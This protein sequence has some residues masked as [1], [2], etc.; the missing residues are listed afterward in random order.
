MIILSILAR[1]RM[2]YDEY[3]WA[4]NKDGAPEFDPNK[5]KFDPFKKSFATCIAQACCSD[6][7]EWDRELGQ[8]TPHVSTLTTKCSYA[9][10]K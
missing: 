10:A 8:C 1:S 7:T 4:F 6:G 3:D 5:R 9:E 2:V